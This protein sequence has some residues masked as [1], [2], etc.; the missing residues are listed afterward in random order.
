V[1]SIGRLGSERKAETLRLRVEDVQDCA[2][3]QRVAGLLPVV[4]PLQRTFGINE[5]VGDILHV[6]HFP[7]AAPDL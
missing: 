2:D 5:R 3:Q 7:F 6:A 4:P 1:V